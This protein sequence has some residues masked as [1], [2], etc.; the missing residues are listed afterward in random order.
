MPTADVPPGQCSGASLVLGYDGV[1]VS[2]WNA[3]RGQ[4]QLNYTW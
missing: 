1:G 3:Y 4:L 2:D